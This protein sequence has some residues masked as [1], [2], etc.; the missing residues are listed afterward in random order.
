MA[1]ERAAQCIRVRKAAMRGHLLGGFM[2]ELQQTP[3]GADAGFL[4][5][6][7]GGD[8]DLGTEQTRKVTRADLHALR[9]AGDAMVQAGIGGNPALQF[10]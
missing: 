5:P 8:S 3:R 4:D 10:L 6:G 9:Q 2:T 1:S 7:R